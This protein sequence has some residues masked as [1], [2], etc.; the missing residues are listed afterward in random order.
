MN[1]ITPSQYHPGWQKNRI[2]FI[3]SKF[4]KDFFRDK[5]ILE[6]APFN[7]YIGAFFHLL[8][9][10]VHCVEGRQENMNNIK[11]CYPFLSVECKD[12]DT[13]YWDLGRYDIII[14]F[15]L[16]Y[17]LEKY[18]KEHLINCINNSSLMFFETVVYDSNN[19][20]IFF[21]NETG[22]D[23]SLSEIGGTPTTS[24]IENILKRENANFNKYTDL[25][26]N[27]GGHHYD[28]EDKNSE[29]YD[30]AS[31]RFWIISKK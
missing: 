31:R 28:W 5:T 11:S 18:H 15:G 1:N 30:Q 17:H 3:L 8:G 4:S 19:D 22:N 7:G 14:N 23:Q 29:V 13:P 20:K 16:Y 10:K 12:L 6:L 24:Y 21:R 26:L 9:A 2:D 25:S 27:S